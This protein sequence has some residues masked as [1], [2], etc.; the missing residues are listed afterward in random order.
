MPSNI[1]QPNLSGPRT[2]TAATTTTNT[3]ITPPIPALIAIQPTTNTTHRRPRHNTSHP[4]ASHSIPTSPL[5]RVQRAVSQLQQITKVRSPVLHQHRNTDAHTNRQPATLPPTNLSVRRMRLEQPQQPHPDRHRMITRH[6]R[7][8]D[9]KLITTEPERR[10]PATQRGLDH[11]R[12]RPKHRVTSLVTKRVVHFLKPV[13][14]DRQHRKVRPQLRTTRNH[15]RNLLLKIT[16]IPKPGQRIRIR[17]VRKR[18]RR[19]TR[20]RRNTV[21]KLPANPRRFQ[22]NAVRLKHRVPNRRNK[23]AH[24]ILRIHRKQLLDRL[25]PTGRRRATRTTG[26]I[27]QSVPVRTSRSRSDRTNDQQ[28]NKR[29]SNN[30][31]QRRL[32]RR[33]T[34]QRRHI[35]RK[36]CAQRNN[37]RDPNTSKPRTLLDPVRNR[38]RTVQ[39]RPPPPN[40]TPNP[41]NTPSTTNAT[42]TT[43][44]GGD[45]S[46]SHT[47]RPTR[48]TFH[49]NASSTRT[50]QNLRP[51]TAAITPIN[52]Q[53]PTLGCSQEQPVPSTSSPSR[54]T[55]MTSAVS[56]RI[57]T[58][59]G[60]AFAHHKHPIRRARATEPN[61]E[62]QES[63]MSPPA[64]LIQHNNTDTFHPSP[65]DAARKMFQ[66]VLSAWASDVL[67][68]R[69]RGLTT[70]RIDQPDTDLTT[71]RQTS[72]TSGRRPARQR[73]IQPA[74]R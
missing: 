11:L 45:S 53:L 33:E 46:P 21:I 14:V 73:T 65:A 28:P 36:T 2:T 22:P 30:R 3:R 59:I 68:L 48:F 15:R 70:P 12:N 61:R 63:S 66:R 54:I 47:H 31:K 20:A 62:T 32:M 41:T 58:R 9:H 26:K 52:N 49:R 13:E 44:R 37:N 16:T 35:P 6:I 29:R 39:R 64:S 17:K 71:L 10:I 51:S 34:A 74:R 56:P 4:S 19:K 55:P 50:P 8:H 7:K 69:A 18:R 5:R 57:R 43:P 24:R 27:K 60:P 25:V 72:R 1:H 42:T 23:L 67:S 40:T 38:T